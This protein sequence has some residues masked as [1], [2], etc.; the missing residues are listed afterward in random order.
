MHGLARSQRCHLC[1]AQFGDRL[2]FTRQDW[3]LKGSAHDAGHLA[4]QAW[5]RLRDEPNDFSVSFKRPSGDRKY[6]DLTI[7]QPRSLD[8][9][10][11]VGHGNLL[12]VGVLIHCA[13]IEPMR[14]RNFANGSGRGRDRLRRHNDWCIPPGSRAQSAWEGAR[15]CLTLGGVSVVCCVRSGEVATRPAI[16]RIGCRWSITVPAGIWR[17]T[18]SSTG[19]QY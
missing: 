9:G 15:V 8:I 12:I 3:R 19:A 11:A 7:F 14:A 6:D 4:R 18:V 13:F 10:P 5:L 17:R 16:E 2:V 1:L